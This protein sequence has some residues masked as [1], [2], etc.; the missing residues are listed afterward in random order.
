MKIILSVAIVLSACTQATRAP[1]TAEE[2]AE[3]PSQ[4]AGAA[5]REYH[6]TTTTLRLFGIEPREDGPVAVIADEATWNTAAF[7]EGDS[8]DRNLIVSEIAR[9]SVVLS[10]PRQRVVLRVGGRATARLVRHASDTVV[11][12]DGEVLL[13]DAG[14]LQ[15][16][17]DRTSDAVD[18]RPF[19][20]PMGVPGLGIREVAA[21]GALAHL[22]LRAG[23]AL[24]AVDGVPATPELLVGLAARLTAPGRE[25]QLRILRNGE[26]FENRYRAR[27]Q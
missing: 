21:Q 25:L 15:D 27:L 2:A 22:G 18:A 5:A 1:V 12:R 3:L 26:V 6:A 7:R 9:D 19:R 20:S 11:E 24:L 17:L 13:V 4:A 8:Y 10:G 23:D 16:I 14:A